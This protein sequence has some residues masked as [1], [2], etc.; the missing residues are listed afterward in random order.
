MSLFLKALNLEDAIIEYKFYQNIKGENGFDNRYHG[1]SFEEFKEQIIK[2][3]I[4]N[5]KGINLKP[6]HVPCTT[7]LL[8][9]DNTIVG[10]Y[11]IR[12]H[13][14][15]ALREGAGHIGYY[16]DP[17]YRKKGYGTKG[18]NL[19][20]KELIKM[21]DFKENEIYLSCLKTNTGSFKTM[22]N[23]GAY[24]H[25]EDNEEFYSRIPVMDIVVATSNNHKLQEYKEMFA[26]FPAI[27]LTSM[28]DEN[29]NVEIIEDG[30]TFK[31][32]SLI[33]ARTVSKYTNKYVLADD[34]GLEIIPLNNFPGI[35][36][37]RF[38]SQFASR[39]EAFEEIFKRLKDSSNRKAQFHCVLS[40]ITP[41]KEEF[42][43]EGVEEGSITN[44][45]SGTNGFGYDPIFYSD[46]LNKTFG[47]ASEEEKN[48]VSHRGRAFIKLSQFLKHK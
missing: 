17:Q 24:V 45:F 48:I 14:N 30:L 28:K 26:G 5:S 12:H 13:L 21:K 31:D 43:F 42:V 1:E 39:E 47:E 37:A 15:D 25:H 7:F 41:Q 46:S 9:D 33:K 4:D 6:N 44:S 8:W 19:A 10:L 18:L 22:L 16:I 3:D 35:Y 29:I 2:T 23:N 20:I 36:S 11:S 40:L 32:N 38:M 27:T 34:S